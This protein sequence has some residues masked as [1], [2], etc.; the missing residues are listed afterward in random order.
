MKKH[1]ESGMSL[2]E[3]IIAG[4]IAVGIGLV[5]LQLSQTMMKGTNKVETDSELMDM[6]NYLKMT[7]GKAGNC[8]LT[9]EQAGY[10]VAGGALDIA[11]LD[12]VQFSEW[13]P[14]TQEY[15]F[16]AA[17]V[18][19]FV[20]DGTTTIQ[21][22]P[23]WKVDKIDILPMTNIV[24]SINGTDSGIC[25]LQMSVN[26]GEYVDTASR[27]SFGA[28]NLVI[29]LDLNC[30]IDPAAPTTVNFCVSD[31]TSRI[32]FWR[33]ADGVGFNPLEGIQYD[34]DVK[35]GQNLI[36]GEHVIIES[37]QNIK[38]DIKRISDPMRKLSGINGYN[39]FLKDK[40]YEQSKQ[41]GLIAQEVE[42]TYPEVVFQQKNGE[43]GVRYTMLIPVLVEAIKKQQEMIDE[44]NIKIENLQ[45]KIDQKK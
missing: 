30:N 4:S 41:I 22:F 13:N 36:V 24:T 31:T 16:D 18:L 44:Q 9:L 11:Q 7:L 38:R 5:V 39:Y 2:L 23:S 15:E 45:K 42:K 43:K 3:V 1:N 19:S 8:A 25:R 32:G 28:R 33:L 20:A 29:G 6:R 34:F 21:K 35:I 14:A 37:D 12:L 10:T 27:R 17:N 26:R 40:R